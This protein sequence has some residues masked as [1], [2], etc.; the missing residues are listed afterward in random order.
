[1][2]TISS[3]GSQISSEHFLIFPYMHLSAML[4]SIANL[5]NHLQLLNPKHRPKP[6][7]KLKRYRQYRTW[8]KNHSV[9]MG[10]IFHIR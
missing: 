6:G 5:E 2:G 7:E 9:S 8:Y 10:M 1:M 3:L 4:L